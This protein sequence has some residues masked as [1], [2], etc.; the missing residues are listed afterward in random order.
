M[1]KPSVSVIVKLNADAFVEA[2]IM[3][4][5]VTSGIITCVEPV[6]IP[7]LQLPAIAQS[8]F[9]FPVQVVLANLYMEISL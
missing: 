1:V 7:L 2:P 5:S 6:G 9:V 8:V 4:A 3:G